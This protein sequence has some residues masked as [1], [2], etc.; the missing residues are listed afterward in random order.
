[1]QGKTGVITAN[2]F[3]NFEV[4]WKSKPPYLNYICFLNVF[5]SILLHYVM[6]LPEAG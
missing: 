1:M 2:K 4:F 5:L 6:I 3:V